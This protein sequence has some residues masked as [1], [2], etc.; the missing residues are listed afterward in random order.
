MEFRIECSIRQQ[1]CKLTVKRLIGE[2]NDA[3]QRYSQLIDVK[4]SLLSPRIVE[5]ISEANDLSSLKS[6][7]TQKLDG[8]LS[9]AFI[10]A[11]EDKE[12]R[13]C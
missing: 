9:Y 1:K 7:V 13:T 4:R 12:K 6:E 3:F 10:E 2:I 8:W 5:L 11:Q